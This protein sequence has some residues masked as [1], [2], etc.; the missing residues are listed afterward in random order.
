M[1]A[2]LRIVT[3]SET[4]VDKAAQELV[5]EYTTNCGM[6]RLP[7]MQNAFRQFLIDGFE[8][9][10]ITEAIMRTARAP[11]PSWAYLEA[12]MR[13]ASYHKAYTLGQF[14]VM[15][16]RSCFDDDLPY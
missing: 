1:S 12:I 13:R 5:R 11:R 8:P 16:R 3:E 14:L 2:A 4:N 6:K 15:P 10:V 7:W 9:A